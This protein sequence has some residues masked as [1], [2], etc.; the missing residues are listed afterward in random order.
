MK[1]KMNK[2]R[3]FGWNRQ[4][5]L[6]VSIVSLLVCAVSGTL[7]Y[8]ID[9]TDPV[10]NIFT[11]GKVDITVTEDFTDNVKNNVKIT[12]TEDSVKAQIR[13]MVVVTWQDN[14]GN[15]Y[16]KAPVEKEDYMIDWKKVGWSGPTDGWYNHGAI[17]PGTSTGILFTD[18]RPVARKAPEGYHLVVDVIAEAIQ[19]DGNASW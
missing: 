19:A 17:E 14:A 15:V 1:N 8:L 11:P 4:T 3:R 10:E 7:A 6:L 5:L 18:C 9:T 2:T 16:P 12:L 13:A